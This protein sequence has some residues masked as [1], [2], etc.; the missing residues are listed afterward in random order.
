MGVAFRECIDPDTDLLLRTLD[1]RKTLPD[2]LPVWCRKPGWPLDAELLRGI[3]E[4]GVEPVIY[5]TSASTTYDR[6]RSGEHDAALRELARKAEGCTLRWDHEPNSE[7]LGAPWH[8]E[9]PLGY[10]D[11][12]RY[13]STVMRS[14][15]D[16]RLW[17]VV[18]GADPDAMLW[19][20]GDACQVV[21]FDRYSRR[22][23]TPLPPDQWRKDV[24][25]LA[26]VGKPVWVS[27][28]GRLARLTRRAKWLRSI[29]DVE[30]VDAVVVMD[31]LVGR[32]DWRWSPS[33]DKVFRE[34][35]A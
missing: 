31:M 29:A 7:G 35:V 18:S 25:R 15:S 33:M 22:P 2:I 12:F 20:P 1:E 3:R 10:V 30:G 17:W 5:A 8:D 11:G 27:E 19:Y 14:V 9:G 32:D 24:E 23:D 21:G 28:C 4:R 16:V 13:V 26:V 34:M 6:I